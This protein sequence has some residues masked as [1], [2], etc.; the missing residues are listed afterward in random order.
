MPIK[1]LAPFPHYFPCTVGVDFWLE[2]NSTVKKI[3]QFFYK[4]SDAQANY[5]GWIDPAFWLP[6][7]YD[8]CQLQT[9]N[10]KMN[11]WWTGHQWEALRL[12]KDDKIMFW[13]RIM[14][15]TS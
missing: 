2:Y 12:K 5:L 14:E 13:K 7:P 1:K 10:K 6:Y 8:L 11:G 3:S 9:S 4:Y 15:E